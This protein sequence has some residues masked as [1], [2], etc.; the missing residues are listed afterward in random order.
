[1]TH[2]SAIHLEEIS[3]PAWGIGFILIESYPVYKQNINPVLQIAMFVTVF[4][5]KMC[6]YYRFI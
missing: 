5:L 4:N 3:I 1:M 6:R 2:W